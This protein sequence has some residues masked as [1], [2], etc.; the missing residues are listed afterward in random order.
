MSVAFS[1]MKVAR[2]GLVNGLK[3]KLM[4]EGEITR[5]WCS[6]SDGAPP[7]KLSGLGNLKFY[8]LQVAGGVVQERLD[9]YR[10]LTLPRP[11][12]EH[13]KQPIRASAARQRAGFE[14]GCNVNQC[15]A[16]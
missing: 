7:G 10:F 9:S 11:A 1:H 16:T 4:G 5:L 6:E 8:P 13:C 2:S 15:M 12:E 14:G 3:L